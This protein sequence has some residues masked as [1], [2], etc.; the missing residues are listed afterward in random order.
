MANHMQDQIL[1]AIKA[2]LIAAATSAGTSVRIE[3]VDELPAASCPAIEI[4]AGR[5]DVELIGMGRR[6]SQRREFDVEVRA[7]VSQSSSYRSAAG[8]LLKQIEQAL[9]PAAGATLVDVLVPDRIRL[10]AST[11]DR[12]GNAARVT[13]TIRTVWRAV[14]FTTEG[15]PDAPVQIT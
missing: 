1:D 6:R 2:T 9:R 3:G 5:E 4:E 8:N 12:D 7:I 10:V 14:Y 11:P 13:Y 15:A